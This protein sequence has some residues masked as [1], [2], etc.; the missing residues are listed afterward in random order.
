MTQGSESIHDEVENSLITECSSHSLSSLCVHE[1]NSSNQLVEAEKSGETYDR[2][3]FHPKSSFEIS[4]NSHPQSMHD[5]VHASEY[6]YVI[7]E[8]SGTYQGI[9]ALQHPLMVILGP[10]KSGKPPKLN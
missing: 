5:L 2:D 6:D 8:S 10:R 7:L 9:K 4:N 3:G 1:D